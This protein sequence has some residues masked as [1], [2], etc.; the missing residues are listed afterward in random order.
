MDKH[1]Q[2][3]EVVNSLAYVIKEA[4]QNGSIVSLDIIDYFL[5][6]SPSHVSGYRILL[7]HNVENLPPLFNDFSKK[8]IISAPFTK[9]GLW[10]LDRET[11]IKMTT[12]GNVDLKIMFCVD[13]D[14]QIVIKLGSA[15]ANGKK[16]DGWR[17]VDNF[18]R[19]LLDTKPGISGLVDFTCIP[20]LLEHL[21]KD[22][23]RESM[24]PAI[25]RN[26]A[27]YLKFKDLDLETY[28]SLR[29]DGSD[30]E[31]KYYIE[32]E[33]FFDDT[34]AWLKKLRFSNELNVA[35]TQSYLYCLLIRM[36]STILLGCSLED[37]IRILSQFAC[38]DMKLIIE[39][40]LVMCFSYL[41]GNTEIRKLFSKLEGA[42]SKFK[43]ASSEI[44]SETK[45][46]NVLHTLYNIAWD[47]THIIMSEFYMRLDFEQFKDT[48]VI[49]IHGLASEDAAIAHA[50]RVV[51]ISAM[52]LCPSGT[53]ITI[54]DPTLHDFW[55]KYGFG[56]DALIDELAR[57]K[58]RGKADLQ[59]VITSETNILK[60]SLK[61]I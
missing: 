37:K 18:L 49:C 59:S 39:Q 55:V 34:V 52:V 13:F 12:G 56:G 22:W 53:L 23:M 25:V 28:N 15:L 51:N 16:S 41:E 46:K 30:L 61:I 50:L 2:E 19:S 3:R 40:G 8:I 58:V 57:E 45:A 31:E 42:L 7:F 35:Q 27:A 21:S 48:D 33:K 54:K 38:N 32:A 36:T 43:Q 9:T 47:M 1:Q 20:Y 60:K 44:D 17:E 29:F 6:E 4:K 10:S 26:I 11:A 24:K 14:S 5:T